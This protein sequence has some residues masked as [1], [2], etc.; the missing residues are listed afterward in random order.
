MPLFH[1]PTLR[2]ELGFRRGSVDDKDL[3]H[4][5]TDLEVREIDRGTNPKV[6]VFREDA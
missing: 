5:I 3:D 4:L 2:Q 1:A 6:F